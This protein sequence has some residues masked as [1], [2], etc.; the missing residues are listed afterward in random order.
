MSVMEVKQLYG[1]SV[2]NRTL[3][4]QYNSFLLFLLGFGEGDRASREERD[5]RESYRRGPSECKL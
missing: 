4:I 1:R 5:E 2:G 3:V